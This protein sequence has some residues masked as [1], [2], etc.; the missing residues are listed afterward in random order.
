[1]QA[2]VA[3][4][5]L[6]RGGSS[7]LLLLA[8]LGAIAVDGV[9]AEPEVPADYQLRD[10]AL[11]DPGGA[12]PIGTLRFE[13][14]PPVGPTLHVV[15]WYPAA[16]A[17]GPRAP[18]LDAE[19]QRVELRSLARVMQWPMAMFDR[20]AAAPTHAIAGAAAARGRFPLLIY[21]HGYFLYPR[22]NSALMERLAAHGY[23]VL[24]LAHPGDAADLPSS[25]GVLPTD[26]SDGGE[27]ID[28][29]K[30]DAF[31]KGPDHAARI[32]ALPG[33]WG[34]QHGT[35]IM[36]S[37]ERWRADILALA[38][39]VAARRVPLEALPIVRA[40]DMRRL[41]YGGMSFGGTTSAS[42][43]RIDRRCR[44]VVNIDGF[45]YDEK[46]YDARMR[47]PLLLVQAD[48]HLYPD[49][50]DPSTVFTPY[51]Y[52]YERWEEAG[53]AKDVYRYRVPDVKHMGMTDLALTARDP[54]RDGIFGP[55]PGAEAAAAV[56][57]I[58][59]AFL[60]RYVARRGADIDAAAARHPQVE[61]HRATHIA[62][63]QRGMGR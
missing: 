13:V 62:Q 26:M 42:A 54:V 17:A 52:A 18:Y 27:G 32:A 30:I 63:W 56:G 10:F 33:F 38:D 58:V 14:K 11:P 5:R 8:S 49:M 39:A 51:D 59:V 55:A 31:L 57:D 48:W 4:S 20:V 28:M 40:T 36:L 46:L 15:A 2:S 41:A 1:M 50:G 25:V 16:S 24:S 37:L 60:D 43:C 19:E 6:R 7:L 45:E 35:R 29:K 3:S 47:A 34:T 61:R 22:Q 9:C 12:H 23:V 44:A 53:A 21:S